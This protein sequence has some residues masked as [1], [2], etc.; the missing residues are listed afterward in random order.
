MACTLLKS[1]YRILGHDFMPKHL[2]EPV[3]L[4]ADPKE[5]ASQCDLVF[6]VVRDEAQTLELCLGE[7]AVSR[8]NFSPGGLSSVLQSVPGSFIKFPAA[9]RP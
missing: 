8:R 6:S 4:I 9:F 5:F 1:G 3:P 7:Q 2:K